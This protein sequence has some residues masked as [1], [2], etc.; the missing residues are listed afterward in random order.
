MDRYFSHVT[1]EK[2]VRNI[3]NYEDFCDIRSLNTPRST[4][5]VQNSI[6]SLFGFSPLKTDNRGG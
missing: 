2:D 6:N 4:F 5:N 3:V 1:P